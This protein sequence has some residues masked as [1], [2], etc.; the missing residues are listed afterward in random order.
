MFCVENGG[1]DYEYRFWDDQKW[2]IVR[3]RD[4][5]F[6][7]QVMY[8]DRLSAPDSEQ[9]SP[10]IIELNISN[11]GGSR[12]DQ[13]E[14]LS[15][16]EDP[17]TPPRQRLAKNR[18]A[19]NRYSPSNF[20][21][22]LT[23]GGEMESYAEAVR[24]DDKGKWK[25][26]MDD[27]RASLTSNDTWRLVELPQGKKALHCKWVYLFKKDV[28]GS[29][30]YKAR[31]VVKGFE[32]RYGIDYTDIFSPVVKLTTIQLVLG[33]VAAEN[34]LL[35]Q[36]DVKTTF[37]HGDL[38]DEIYMVQPEGYV[39]EGNE[40]LVCKLVKS[41]YGLKQTPKQWYNKF[42]GFMRDI[43]FLRC[44]SDNCCYYKK[45]ENC[46]L[47]LLL[48]VD[49]MLIAGASSKEIEKLKKQLSECFSMKELG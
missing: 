17:S 10:K 22:L 33:L 25:L 18:R 9:E 23:D 32:Q 7:E 8:K 1:D 34:L 40:D 42:D 20:Y 13:N 38:N 43:N 45:F 6:N 48:Y 24:V 11:S 44:H 2:K 14:E 29:K 12:Q 4:V 15:S 41:L 47:I 28:D 21:L 49:D 16:D 30:R 5:V 37:L 36:M 35:H 19:P 3:S 46:Y 27:E 26:A 31:L 39:A